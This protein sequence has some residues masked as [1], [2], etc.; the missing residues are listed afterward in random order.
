MALADTVAAP[1]SDTMIVNMGP[2]HPSTHGVL[3]LEL[4]LDGE[5]VVKCTPHIGYLHTGIEKEMETRNYQQCV[6]MT[7]RTD[8]LNPLGNNLG[9]ALAVEKLFECEIPPRA[10]VARVLLVE[11]QRIASHLVWLGTHALDLGAM[12]AF[13]YCFRERELLLDIFEL[14]SG[15]RLMTSYIRPGGLAMDLPPGFEAQVQKF[16][17]IFPAK[18]DDYEALLTNNEIFI[19]RT[20]GIGY[21]TANQAIALGV[22]GPP[23]RASG[24]RRDI[25]KDA[26]YSGYETFDFD[27]PTATDG[28][29]YARYTLR[30][31]E[32]RQSHRI[33]QQALKR[34]P[35]GPF[36]TADRKLSLPPRDELYTSMESLIHHFKL[37]TEGIK[38]PAGEVYAAVESP[39]GEL[40]YYIVS[41]GSG[42]PYR[43]HMRAP[44]F[45][46]LQALGPI[47]EGRLIA[48]AVACIGSLDPVLGEV[49]R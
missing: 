26:P 40:G 9:F 30:V 5:T 21:L 14:C 1:R 27:V 43:V 23:L 22:T 42:K 32:M 24:V 19:D 4:I 45:V 41:D 33:A 29:V 6:T 25:R 46:N 47:M 12:T 49:D 8:Y 39:R 38:P 16:L 37:V 7:D 3:R 35:S 44:S 18:V 2:Q 13:W 34:L 48:D 17:D 31:A 11:L 36:R 20:K 15:A 28:D 10:Q